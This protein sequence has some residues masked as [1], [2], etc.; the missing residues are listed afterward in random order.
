MPGR[1]GRRLRGPQRLPGRR[2]P[3]TLGPPPR[4]NAAP[5]LRGR[6]VSALGEATDWSMSGAI[7]GD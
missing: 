4:P 3:G 1:P 7:R 6:L 2:A 5:S